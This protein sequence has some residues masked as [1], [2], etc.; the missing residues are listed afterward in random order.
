MF[1]LLTCAG[2]GAAA[3]VLTASGSHAATI[4]TDNAANAP[5]TDGWSPGDNGGTGWAGGW[6]FRNQSNTVLN[7]TNGQRGWFWGDSRGN[8]N[9]AGDT[10]NDFDI[11]TPSAADGKAWGLYSNGTTLDQVYAIRP[12]S[13][14]A[15]GNTIKW[16][17]DNGNIASTQVVGLRLL[18]NANDI[19]SRVFEHRFVGG[20]ANYTAF[21]SPTQTTS[22]GFTREGLRVEYTLTTATTYSLKVTRK[23]DGSSQTITGNNVNG[24]PIVAIAF[25]NQFA[26]SGGASDAFLNNISIMSPNVNPDVQNHTVLNVNASIPGLVEHTFVGTDADM[27]T[28]TW[29]SFTF[30]TYTPDYGGGPGGPVQPGGSQLATFNPSTRE[31]DWNTVGS[32]RG[33][34][35][36]NVTASDGNG[37]SDVGTITVHVTAVPEPTTLGLLVVAMLGL[38]SSIRRA[39]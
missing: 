39:H 24:N 2:I 37:G 4:A 7:A 25:K 36:W 22:L 20:D 23:V 10:N 15:V 6:T 31:F 16:D 38:V 19:N 9:V 34:Y 3:L 21:G 13:A 35:T 30:G 18:T 29:G 14:L 12:F 17:I 1:R 28:L 26:G 11:N 32:P 5:Y 33:I 27:D 8:D